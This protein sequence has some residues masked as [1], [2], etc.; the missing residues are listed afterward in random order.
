M[1]VAKLRNRDQKATIQALCVFFCLRVFICYRLCVEVSFTF[2]QHCEDNLGCENR[3]FFLPGSRTFLRITVKV[4]IRL[5]VR[6][7][8]EVRLLADDY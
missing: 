4:Q 1:T 3:F 2:R 5:R 6:V 8:D 7:R